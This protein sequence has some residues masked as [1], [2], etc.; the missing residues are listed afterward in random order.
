[1]L[2]TAGERFWAAF[3]SS[4]VGL[5][6]GV[7]LT[8]SRGTSDTDQIQS[9][10]AGENK[11]TFRCRSGL[12]TFNNI[13]STFLSIYTQLKIQSIQN[14]S[15]DMPDSLRSACGGEGAVGGRADA[16]VGDR[17]RKGRLR[18]AVSLLSRPFI[19]I[20]GTVDKP[21]SSNRWRWGSNQETSVRRLV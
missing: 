12:A 6:G 1:M 9:I 14:S 17:L 3:A 4:T 18:V 5:D 20:E 13:R 8:A 19:G 2:R 15:N 10:L 16:G 21:G 7:S 11:R